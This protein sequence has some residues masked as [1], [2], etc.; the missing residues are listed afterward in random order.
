M[1]PSQGHRFTSGTAFGFFCSRS[2]SAI[3]SAVTEAA[4][5]GLW[6]KLRTAARRKEQGTFWAAIFFPAW[7]TSERGGFNSSTTRPFLSRAL[8]A[9]CP[10]K[11]HQ[12]RRSGEEPSPSNETSVRRFMP[13]LS[14]SLRPMTYPEG[15]S[16]DGQANEKER[17]GALAANSNVPAGE[18][19]LVSFGFQERQL[20]SGFNGLSGNREGGA[21][22]AVARYSRR[23]RPGEARGAS[24]GSARSGG[25]AGGFGAG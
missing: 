6:A 8:L 16:K 3:C 19:G 23:D 18:V 12:S 21:G 14:L 5:A 25:K 13:S 22:A 7:M 10:K 15:R 11:A 1:I 9:P 2:F 4:A 20:R 17:S 24:R